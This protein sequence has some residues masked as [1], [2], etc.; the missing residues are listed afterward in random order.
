MD[1]STY[2]L[3]VFTA[4]FGMACFFGAVYYILKTFGGDFDTKK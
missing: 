2:L 3:G 4:L 1:E